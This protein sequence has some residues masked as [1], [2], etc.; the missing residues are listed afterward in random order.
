MT[1]CPFHEEGVIDFCMVL[2]IPQK[3]LNSEEVE[4]IYK[5]GGDIIKWRVIK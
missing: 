1:L 3:Y 2:E 5:K 4:A